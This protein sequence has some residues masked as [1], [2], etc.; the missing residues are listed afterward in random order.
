MIHL[1]EYLKENLTRIVDKF[2]YN[3]LKMQITKIPITFS[4]RINVLILADR[5]IGRATGLC[6]YLG[7]IKNI[8]VFFTNSVEGVNLLCQHTKFDFLI[9][10]GYLK[11]KNNYLAIKEIKDLNKNAVVIIYT[12]SNFLIKNECKK[13]MFKNKYNILKPA[14]NFIEYM[15]SIYIKC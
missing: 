15:R 3:R 5:C 12:F 4:Y 9:I 6:E 11:N 10:S 13:Y 8:K 1:F 14:A 7:N 2:E